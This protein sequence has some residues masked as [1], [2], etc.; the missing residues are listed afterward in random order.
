MVKALYMDDSYLREWDAV[1]E[2]VSQKKFIILDKTAFFPKGGGVEYDIGTITTEDKQ[3]FNVVYTGKFSGKISHEVEKAGLQE[4][5]KVH[6][7][8]DWERRYLLMRYHTATHVLSGVLFKDYNLKVTGNQLT[9]DKARV[10]LNMAEM[11]VNIIIKS[12]EKSN[13]IIEKKLPVDIFYKSREEAEKEP[14]LFKLAIGFPHD[15]DN[16]RIVDIKGFDKQADG[17]CHVKNLKEIGTII[18]KDFINKGKNFKRVY[19]TIE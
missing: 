4:G 2:S 19:F 3:V 18:F 14:D 16:L 5:D 6:C 9:T 15:I 17:G 11:D 7:L 10:D 8:L 1:V 13:E 12:I